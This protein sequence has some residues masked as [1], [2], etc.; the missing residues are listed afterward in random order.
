MKLKIRNILGISALVVGAASLAVP[1]K[2]SAL[3]A[4]QAT[5]LQD[6]SSCA[7]KAITDAQALEACNKKVFECLADSN[8]ADSHFSSQIV[9]Y[10]GSRVDTTPTGDTPTKADVP[11]GQV[12]MVGIPTSMSSPASPSSRALPAIHGLGTSSM[13]FI[14]NMPT[15]VAAPL[16]PSKIATGGASLPSHPSP[17]NTALAQ[18]HGTPVHDA[19]LSHLPNH[20]EMSNSHLPRGEPNIV[21]GELPLAHGVPDLHVDSNVPAPVSSDLSKVNQFHDRHRMNHRKF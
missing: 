16:R 11:T 21:P 19:S 7:A 10:V 12:P 20:S 18:T 8:A 6:Y 9:R 13:P 5:C 14:P 3:D 15:G 1:G 4:A 2:Q 17:A